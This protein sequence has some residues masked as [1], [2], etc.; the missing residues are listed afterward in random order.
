MLVLRVTLLCGN[1]SIS[2]IDVIISSG[3]SSVRHL[4]LKSIS[5]ALV[6]R[7]YHSHRPQS[8]C[9]TYCL[10]VMRLVFYSY[11]VDDHSY[12]YDDYYD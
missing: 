8:S 6:I 2:L 9:V 3:S 10:V 11:C 7:N 1:C 5:I 12:D 4:L